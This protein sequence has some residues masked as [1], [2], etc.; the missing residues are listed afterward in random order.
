VRHWLKNV[1]SEFDRIKLAGLV[2]VG[3]RL[4]RKAS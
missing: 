1:W 3:G 2:G 4:E